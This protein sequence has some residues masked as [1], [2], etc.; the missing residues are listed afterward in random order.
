MELVS[1]IRFHWGLQGWELVH[2]YFDQR[3]YLTGI[4]KRPLADGAFSEDEEGTSQ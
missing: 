4:F 1:L 2:S 3:G